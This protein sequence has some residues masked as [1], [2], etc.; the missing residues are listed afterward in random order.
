VVSAHG[1]FGVLAAWLP[2]CQA[3][4]PH[5]A[6]TT[7]TTTQ[8]PSSHPCPL[9]SAPATL[10][11]ESDI[12]PYKGLLMGLFFMTVGMEISVALFMEK[13]KTIILAIVLLV[14]GRR[15]VAAALLLHPRLPAQRPLPIP[16]PLHR[17]RMPRPELALSWCCRRRLPA[18]G[19]QAGRHGRH[20]PHVWP[21]QDGVSEGGPAAGAR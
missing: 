12:A 5:A 1:A 11:V 17:H 20:R 8:K 13:W 10:Q 3:N 6:P 7:T 21:Q 14:G 4:I 18:G 19:R 15:L 2:W 16:Q 9:S